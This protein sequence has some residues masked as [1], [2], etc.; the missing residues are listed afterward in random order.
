MVCMGNM[1]AVT[2]GFSAPE[3]AEV[4][5]QARTLAQHLG[6]DESLKILYGLSVAAT[7]RAEFQ[8]A[9]AINDAMLKITEGV[10]TA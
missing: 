10:G 3:T 2:R 4:Y 8:P 5:A 9:M 1:M 6:S 7:T